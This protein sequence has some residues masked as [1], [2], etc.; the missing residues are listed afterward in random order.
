[1]G[2]RLVP[3]VASLYEP[4]ANPGLPALAPEPQTGDLQEFE[5]QTTAPAPASTHTHAQRDEHAGNPAAPNNRSAPEPAPRQTIEMR[6]VTQLIQTSQ[7]QPA[8]ASAESP[9]LPANQTPPAAPH[10][11]QPAPVPAAVSNQGSSIQPA[12]QLAAPAAPNTQAV[13]GALNAL[14]T[15][16]RASAQPTRQEQ[17]QPEQPKTDHQPPGAVRIVPE[18]IIISRRELQAADARRL[19][20]VRAA[21]QPVAL[22]GAPQAPSITVTIGRIE[23]KA[24][25]PAALPKRAA[26]APASL[27]LDEYLRQRQGGSR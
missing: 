16:E 3:R 11:R 2:G 18:Q 20:P 23:I 24:N 22:P 7:N 14:S 10:L 8:P 5:A 15:Q 26:P 25:T 9:R 6:Q 21:A 1:M 13:R 27:S 19:T 4:L 12:P 17:E